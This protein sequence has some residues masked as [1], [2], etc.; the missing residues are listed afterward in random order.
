MGGHTDYPHD[1][2]GVNSDRSKGGRIKDARDIKDNDSKFRGNKID[3][4]TRE[5][6]RVPESDDKARWTHFDHSDYSD[7]HDN[8]GYDVYTNTG[9][10]DHV[11]S[12]HDNHTNSGHDTHTDRG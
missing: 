1:N 6:N 5:S 9:H 8:Y 7:T 10:D 2:W 4:N 3:N 11:N 12:G